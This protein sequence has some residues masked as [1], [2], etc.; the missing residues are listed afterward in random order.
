MADQNDVMKMLGDLRIE[1]R[2]LSNNVIELSTMNKNH[3]KVNQ[4]NTEKIDAIESDT[5]FAKGSIA[6]FKGVGIALICF[7]FSSA[8]TFGTWIVTSNYN[9]QAKLSQI[10]LSIAVIKSE[11]KQFNRDFKNEKSESGSD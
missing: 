4:S 7:G 5:Q 1:I 3:E 11:M 8:I 10:E 6:L 2:D 9:T